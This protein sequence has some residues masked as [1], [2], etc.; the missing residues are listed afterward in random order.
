MFRYIG[1]KTKL[2]PYIM[3]A[4]EELAGCEGTVCDLMAGTG[5][6]SLA[7]RKQGYHV[8]ASDIMTY[9]YHHLSVLLKLNCAPTFTSLNPIIGCNA[10]Y[11]NVLKYLN[12]LPGKEGYFFNEFSSEGTP[13]NGSPSRKYFTSDNAK[14][15]DSIRDKINEWG[16]L[17][18]LSD[19]ERS[20]LLHSLILSVNDVANISGTYGYFLANYSK[21]SLEPFTIKP[22]EFFNYHNTDNQVIEIGRASCRERV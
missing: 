21:S 1:N 20:V 12:S 11:K 8:I 5:S 13:K 6:V 18:L 4:I 22:C 19:I 7:L 17:S 2:L 10:T 15:I 3:E 9:S 14:K 16:K